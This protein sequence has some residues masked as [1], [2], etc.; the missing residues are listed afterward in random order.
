MQDDHITYAYHQEHEY[1]FSGSQS[2]HWPP[3]SFQQHPAKLCCNWINPHQLPAWCYDAQL[4]TQQEHD[5]HPIFH[6]GVPRATPTWAYK[7]AGPPW[8]SIP[9]MGPLYGGDAMTAWAHQ[10]AWAFHSQTRPNHRPQPATQGRLGRQRRNPLYAPVEQPTPAR[11]MEWVSKAN[12]NPPDKDM[13]TIHPARVACAADKRTTLI[14]KNIPVKVTQERFKALVSQLFGGR[15]DFV[16]VP[17]DW[18]TGGAFGYAFVNLTSAASVLPFYE[19]F[20]GFT[21][22]QSK[23][24]KVWRVA[25]ARIQGMAELEAHF[26][27]R[28][29]GAEFGVVARPQPAV[30][31][32]GTTAQMTTSSR[33]SVGADEGAV[34][35]REPRRVCRARARA[36]REAAEA[37]ATAMPMKAL[38]QPPAGVEGTAHAPPALHR[39][40]VVSQAAVN[41]D[42]AVQTATMLTLVISVVAANQWA[43]NQCASDASED[44]VEVE[45]RMPRRVRRARARAEREAA[46]A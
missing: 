30:L 44:V 15:I 40:A 26:R 28:Q 6:H 8:Q 16:Y 2:L 31:H 34:E 43:A 21:L 25:Y 17:V 19:R 5:H 33:P 4:P 20:D 39:A 7:Q 22:P 42:D 32:G 38:C 1:T 24:T 14:I 10:Q 13:F 29:M 12:T 35:V 41:T 45:A 11:F 9:Q 36:E 18:R 37:E 3:L 23:S 27:A 46:G